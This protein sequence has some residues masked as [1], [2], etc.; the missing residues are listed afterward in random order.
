MNILV[1][2]SQ[3][4]NVKPR[5]IAKA[6]TATS[7]GQPLPTDLADHH[8]RGHPRRVR[9]PAA[10]AG[11]VR[12]NQHDD[13]HLQDDAAACSCHDGDTEQACRRTVSAPAGLPGDFRTGVVRRRALDLYEAVPAQHHHERAVREL[14]DVVAS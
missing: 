1:T 10:G 13:P 14:R 12:A 4:A 2:A 7:T 5:M 8:A 6:V 11:A 9:E 3:H